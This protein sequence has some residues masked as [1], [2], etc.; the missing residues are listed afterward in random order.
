MKFWV[1]WVRVRKYPKIMAPMMI[2]K[3]MVVTLMDPVTA[4]LN[5]LLVILLRISGMTKAPNAPQAAASVGV[6]NPVYIE[7]ITTEANRMNAQRGRM[8]PH[9]SFQV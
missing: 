1:V 6:A 5:E 4:F 9:R 2:V 8:D 7:P 3:I